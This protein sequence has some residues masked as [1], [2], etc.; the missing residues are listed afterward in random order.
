MISVATMRRMPHYLRL[1]KSYKTKDRE[2]I[3]C[4][5][6][7]ETLQLT[8]IQ[9]RKDLAC[10]GIVGK[11]KTGYEIDALISAIESFLGWNNTRDAFLVGAGNLGRALLGYKGFSD[12]N[13]NIAAAFDTNEALIGQ[14]IHGKEILHLDKM[15]NL[16]QRMHVHIG[17]LTVPADQAQAIADLM[18]FSEIR[19]IWNFAPVKL[20]LRPDMIVENVE[21]S[22]SLAVLTSKLNQ[23]MTTHSAS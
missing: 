18:V 23:S 1:L 8:A 3:S 6:I 10:T 12:Y 21:L 19:A 13:L 9:V 7:A 16:A 22:A 5:R 4:T 20:Q 17:I 14:T 11:P 15:Q 2:I